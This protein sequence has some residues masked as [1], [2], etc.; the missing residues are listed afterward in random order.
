MFSLAGIA[1]LSEPQGGR[2]EHLDPDLSDDERLAIA[3]EWMKQSGRPPEGADWPRPVV[4]KAWKRCFVE[5]GLSPRASLLPPQT[6]MKRERG[7]PSSVAADRVVQAAL[8]TMAFNLNVFL[9]DTSVGLLLADRTGALVH[10]MNA[11]SNLGP[12]GCRLIR[13]GE[14]WAE[15]V[16]GN[17]GLGSAAVLGESVAFNGKEHF[18]AAL[19]PFATAGHPIFGRD[20][21]LAAVLG[22][23]TDQRSSAQT[24]LGFARIASHLVEMNLFESQTPDAFLLRLRSNDNGSGLTGQDCLLHGLI[25][26]NR[27]GRI[28]AATRTGLRLVG[29]ESISDIMFRKVETVLGVAADELRRRAALSE[30]IELETLAGRRLRAEIIA[31]GHSGKGGDEASR[32]PA[33]G[34]AQGSSRPPV[35]GKARR[36]GAA[37]PWR[38][39]VLE[40]A[41]QKA[42]SSQRQK[43][44][45]LITGETGVGKDHLVRRLHQEG[46]RRDCPLVL[47]NCAGIPRD[48][49][50]S[51]L[52]GYVSGSFTGAQASGKSGRFVDAHT[53][54]LFL[55]EIG[56]MPLDLQTAL[57]CALDSS[58]IIPV[59]GSSAVPVDVQVVAATNRDLLDCV[60]IGAF[61]RDLYYRLNGVQFSLP[62]LRDRPDKLGLI[63]HLWL[64]EMK[65]QGV[66]GKV[67]SAE[68]RDIFERHPWPG[69]VR[70]LRNVL[71]SC[72]AMTVGPET[73]VSDL[74]SDFLRET[75]SDAQGDQESEFALLANGKLGAE[76]HALA[77]WEAEAIRASLTKTSGNISESARQLGITRQALYNKMAR[78]GL[79]K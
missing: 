50:A 76:G 16:I 25:S 52:F 53:G 65:A 38:D 55:D 46:A 70:E 10:A 27:E 43:I 2:P 29:V 11:G 39:V 3:W 33:A 13:L 69:N 77:F 19:H 6:V 35:A 68:V 47:L 67:L 18:S 4:S 60:R 62:P 61:R 15:P 37:E 7:E 51:E 34:R 64:Q 63:E 48:L 9:K 42:V 26:L 59:G 24:L 17:N 40:A 21:S 73:L 32:I 1:G 8:A 56:D 23:I 28:V 57:L 58:S 5:Y 71:R 79:R 75:G 78:H 72:V 44:P 49:I 31:G 36:S 22:L 14:S 45:I 66:E 54:V 74:P 41:L 20:G 30:S 12:I